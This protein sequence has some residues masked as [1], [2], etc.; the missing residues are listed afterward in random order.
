MEK[1]LWAS[2]FVGHDRPGHKERVTVAYLRD[3][4][5][6]ADKEDRTEQYDCLSVIHD[7]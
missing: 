4:M 6:V 1:I 2:R 3:T 5:K 7:A